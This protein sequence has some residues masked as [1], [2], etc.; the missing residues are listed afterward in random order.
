MDELGEVALT[1]AE[2]C[3][4]FFG[5]KIKPASLRSEARR[6]NLHI[7]R[8]GRMDFVTPAAIREMMVK[9]CHADASHQGSTSA[10]TS[11]SGS[12]ETDQSQYAQAAALATAEALKKR[13][14]AT[15]TKSTSRSSAKV[16][17]LGSGSTRS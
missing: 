3:Q 13:L 10:K 4:R 8:I 5:G 1:L 17:R 2:A 11:K 9:K 12:S 14:P 6:G 16:V 7:A 15:S